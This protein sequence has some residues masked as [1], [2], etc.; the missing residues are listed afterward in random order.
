MPLVPAPRPASRIA[1][2][3]AAAALA[4]ALAACA[5]RDVPDHL[6]GYPQTL[7]A[8]G[9]MAM[10]QMRR[11]HVGELEL[12]DAA[13]AVYGGGA[14]SVWMAEARDTARAARFV[15]DMRARIGEGGTP[16]HVD[17]TAT[18]DGR[19]VVVLSGMGQRHGCFRAG[20][21]VV[22]VAAQRRVAD[23]AFDEAIAYY[24]DRGR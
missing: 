8:R 10:R 19:A 21:R 4:V 13:F 14:V 2:L 11:L 16:F 18:L 3:A 6:A 9:D 17:S 7:V 20:R 12:R 1:A 24:G 15:A 5:H 23:G 22:W